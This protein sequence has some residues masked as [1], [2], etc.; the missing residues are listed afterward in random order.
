M[1]GFVRCA[2]KY[3]GHENPCG[4]QCGIVVHVVKVVFHCKDRG[5]PLPSAGANKLGVDCEDCRKH[6]HLMIRRSAVS[7]MQAMR[8]AQ[9]EK[10]GQLMAEDRSSSRSKLAQDPSGD[11]PDRSKLY[12][13]KSYA[14]WHS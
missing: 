4:R 14:G 8:K 5:E 3:C 6:A 9:R 13:R 7:L 10:K 1:N 2:C 11:Q 12:R